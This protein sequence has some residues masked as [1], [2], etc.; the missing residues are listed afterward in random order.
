MRRCTVV[1]RARGNARFILKLKIT[2]SRGRVHKYILNGTSFMDEAPS[3]HRETYEIRKSARYVKPDRYD[4]IKLQCS[5]VQVDGGGFRS[6]HRHPATTYTTNFV[7]RRLF[8]FTRREPVAVS[9]VLVRTPIIYT[10][11]V[12]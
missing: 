7:T 11:Y 4:R 6:V 12:P 9:C 10:F 5:T 2:L 3:M 1:V 8:E